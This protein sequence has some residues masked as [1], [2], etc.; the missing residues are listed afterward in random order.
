MQSG[1][2]LHT[3]VSTSFGRIDLPGKAAHI[4][5]PL[6]FLP[7]LLQKRNKLVRIVDVEPQL[8]E[9]NGHQPVPHLLVHWQDVVPIT[10]KVLLQIH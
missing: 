6:I 4:L 2:S 7:K 1:T 9:L 10:A 8:S 3:S 5:E